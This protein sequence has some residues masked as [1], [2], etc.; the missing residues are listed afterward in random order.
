MKANELKSNSQL[1]T[2][3]QGFAVMTLVMG[4]F[5][6]FNNYII[7]FVERRRHLAIFRS[8]GMS[9]KQIV[10]MM[11]M[12]ALT[13]GLIGGIAGTAGGAVSLFIAV[14]LL[15]SMDANVG[16]SVS[17][18]VFGLCMVAS[19]FVSLIA[20][21]SPALKSGRLNIIEAIKYE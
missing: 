15:R 5:G 20:S 18:A 14:Y 19:L 4:L 6:V 13:G 11:L 12:E 21:L 16:M 9:R 10:R 1:M 8:V 17:P 3:L 2:L 7:S